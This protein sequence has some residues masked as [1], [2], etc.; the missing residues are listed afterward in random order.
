MS[1]RSVEVYLNQYYI[2]VLSQ[3]LDGRTVLSFDEQ[4]LLDRSRPT[5]S[6]SYQNILRDVRTSANL[7]SPSGKLSPFFSNLLP[8][9]KLRTYLAARA[10]VRETQEFSLLVALS[11]DLSGA[12][13]LR[14]DKGVPLPDEP[15]G[16][17][18]LSLSAGKGKL[19]FSL[20]GV[21]LKFSGDLINSKL[22][23]PA[24]GVGGHWVVKLPSPSFPHL[25]ELEYSML[26]LAEE[27]GITVAENKLLPLRDFEN[28]PTDLPE[29]LRGDCLISKR[30]DRTAD[31]GR[32][33]MEDF[34]QVFSVYEKYDARY[35]YQ[36]IAS[37]LWLE[38]G[39]DDV[40]EFVRRLVHTFALGNADM[41]LKNWSVIYPDTQ[42]AKL[43]PAYDLVSTIVYPG[44]SRVLPHK[45]AGVRDFNKIGIADFKNF[46]KIAKLPERV[47]VKTVFETVDSLKSSWL[48]LRAE[49]PIPESFKVIIEEH[50]QTVP[51]LGERQ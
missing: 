17:P 42:Q 44:I 39:L 14:G 45:I 48:K 26:R 4:Y 12:T 5:L 33:H 3:L 28:L 21:Q 41:H 43:S 50:M 18:E 22:V 38:S 9:G 40:L 30:F 19:R 13:V 24:R 11:E 23:I 27:I 31:G 35:N 51:L 36:S 2:G 46:A 25:N 32:V 29:Q 20:A 16:D 49:L 10:G 15:S 1:S 47:V 6:L 37:V 34:A 8:E 7:I